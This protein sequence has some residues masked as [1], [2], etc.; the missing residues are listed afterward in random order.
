[1]QVKIIGAQGGVMKGSHATSL[2]I[3]ESLLI[4]AG[5][6]A[7]GLD[8]KDQ[9][10][11]DHI[12]VS[13]AHLDHIKDLAFI[14]DNC[15]GMRENPFEV[16]CHPQVKKSI[17]DHL[18]NDII[19]PDFSI[20]PNSNKP[21]ISFNEINE[22]VI[23]ELGDY[24]VHPVH[25]KHPGHAM[26][27]IVEKGD[28]AVL[29]TQDTGPTDKIWEK[30]KEFKNLKAIFTE[31]S[32]PN[33]LQNVANLSDHHTPQTMA[34][35]ILKMP[36]DIPIYLSHLKPTNKEELISEINAIGEKRLHI[37]YM[38]DVRFDF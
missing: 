8:I 19:W 35:E 15:F 2:L 4:D 12:L 22:G 14:C 23:L 5:S 37:L 33:E 1:M 34:K 6:V 7:S 28:C 17:K 25:V 29:F 30:A 36:K 11:I 18:F 9:L 27:F 21:T 16:Y 26:G 31:V 38:D 13:H 3:D 20:L 24:R 10:A 32:F